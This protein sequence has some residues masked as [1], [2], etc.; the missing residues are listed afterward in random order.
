MD[1]KKAAGTRTRGCPNGLNRFSATR[2]SWLPPSG[3][4]RPVALRHRLSAVLPFS[5][6]QLSAG[7]P[8][9]LAKISTPSDPRGLGDAFRTVD[10]F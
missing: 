9:A 10:L 6:F 3:S 2:R 5:K 4:F 7:G 8:E 1:D